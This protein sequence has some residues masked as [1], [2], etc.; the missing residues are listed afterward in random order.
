[1]RRGRVTSVTTFYTISPDN[2]ERHASL[3]LRPLPRHAEHRRRAGRHAGA[4]GGAGIALMNDGVIDGHGCEAGRD[5]H[6]VG[7]L[8]RHSSNAEGARYSNGLTTS[9]HRGARM[10]EHGGAIDGFGASVR[11][12]PDSKGAVIILVNG[13]ARGCRK[14]PSGRSSCSRRCGKRRRDQRC[15]SRWT[16]ASSPDP[17][18]STRTDRSGSR[19]SSWFATGSCSSGVDRLRW[20]R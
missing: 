11:V 5:L 2:Q 19:S 6:A 17:P 3:R 13:A 8:R 20:V 1:M 18:A 4:G 9:T 10:V 15:R 12:L 14:H 7:R 16:P